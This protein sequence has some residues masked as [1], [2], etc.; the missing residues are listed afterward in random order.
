MRVA[1]PS[2][3]LGH[4]AL[5]AAI[6]LTEGIACPFARA[7][8]QTEASE[9]VG[10]IVANLATGQV[11]IIAAHDGFLVA[12]IGKPFEPGDFPPVIVRLGETSLAVVVGAVDW[13]EP[14]TNR[15]VLQLTKQLPGLIHGLGGG[16][17]RLSSSPDIS[18]LRELGLAVLDHLRKAAHNLHARIQLP[19]DRPLTELIIVRQPVRQTGAVWDLRYWLHQTFLEENF[20]NTEVQRPSYSQLFP[21]K[22]DHSGLLE[23]RYPPGASSASLLEWLSQPTGRLAQ[24]IETN[25]KLAKQQRL[26]AEGKGRKTKLGDLELLVKTAMETMVPASTPKAVAALDSN[27]GFAWI[28]EPSANSQEPKRPPGAPT[29]RPHP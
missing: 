23:I 25:P 22:Q 4:L 6:L 13:V 3:L 8:S 17:P 2:R 5:A 16:A 29:L 7:A 27:G 14:P 9:K 1:R 26:I 20:W 10:E 21:L 24:A 28:I 15:P 11:T 18:H 12:A 19:E